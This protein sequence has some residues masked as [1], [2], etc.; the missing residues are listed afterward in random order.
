MSKNVKGVQGELCVV[1][2]RPGDLG[3]RFQLLCGN[4][5]DGD[6]YRTVANNRSTSAAWEKVLIKQW[7]TAG[8]GQ[9]VLYRDKRGILWVIDGQHR[10]RIASGLAGPTLFN[11]L[12]Y[13]LEDLIRLDITLRHLVKIYN[14][15]RRAGTASDRET[16]QAFSPWVDAAHARGLKVLFL[17]PGR[18]GGLLMDN[19]LKAV[20][21]S[22][23]LEVGAVRGRQGTRRMNEV[24]LG[25]AQDDIERCM[26]HIQWWVE[27][28]VIPAGDLRLGTKA[29]RP[30]Y[31][32]ESLAFAIL[33]RQDPGNTVFP[34]VVQDIPRRLLAWPAF[35]QLVQKDLGQTFINFLEAINKGRKNR[36]VL[37]GGRWKEPRK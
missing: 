21:F 34:Q 35:T 17:R 2:V 15:G 26:G 28:V 18:A 36:L 24:F 5:L 3:G 33:I 22:E 6:R 20:L 9:L 23:T 31:R 19:I 32:W 11:A 7:V 25:Y 37:Q 10:I 30:L 13:T 14:K 29:V 12:I 4:E 16:D 27:E 8:G 1:E